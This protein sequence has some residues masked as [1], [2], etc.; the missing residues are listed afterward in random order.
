MTW[1]KKIKKIFNNEKTG[2]FRNKLLFNKE[3]AEFRNLEFFDFADGDLDSFKKFCEKCDNKIIAKPLTGYSGLGIFRPDLSKEGA[4][5]ELYNKLVESGEFFCEQLFEQ[6]GILHE[7]N[8]SSS[9]TVRIY[10]INNGKIH[11]PFAGVR[12]G[13]STEV[14]DNIHAGGMCCQVDLESGIVIS[15]GYNLSGDYYIKHPLSG[16]I[17]NG[18]QIPRW[19]EVKDYV[20]RAAKKYPNQGYV[21]WDIA[22]SNSKVSIIEGN[23]GGNFDLPQVC[24]QRGCKHLYEEYIKNKINYINT[25]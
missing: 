5:E 1:N 20:Y 4:C 17:I 12:F 15:H 3:F 13:G 18:I 23:D 2:V 24:M 10:T 25:I 9:N 16:I 14:V 6:N 21:A 8:P 7:V 19:E 22:V 11:I